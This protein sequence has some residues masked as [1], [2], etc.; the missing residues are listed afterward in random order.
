ML[1]KGQIEAL[2]SKIISGVRHYRVKKTC[3]KEKNK[4]ERRR[5]NILFLQEKWSREVYCDKYV[6]SWTQHEGSIILSE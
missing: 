5:E 2:D 1:L 6:P 4:K 3:E